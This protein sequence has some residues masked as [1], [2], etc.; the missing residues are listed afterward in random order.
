MTNLNFK[1][2]DKL[3]RNDD[4][5]KI[6]SDT[7]GIRFLKLR[8]MSRKEAMEEFCALHEINLEGIKSKDYFETVFEDRNITDTQISEYINS[9]YQEERAVRA[10]NQEYLVDQLNR[11]QHFDWGGSFGNSLEKNIVNN[12]VKKIQS[13]DKIN[14]EIEGSLLSSMRGYTLNSWYNH[15]TSIIIEDLF[16]DHSSVLPT[17]GLVKKIDFFIND[18][19]F[20]LKVTYFPEQLLADKL[21]DSGYG[22]ELTKLKQA[23]RSLRIFIPDD[24]NPKELK[25]HLLNK[26]REDHRQEAKS[27]VKELG[28]AKKEI[29]EEAERN[30]ADLKKWFYENQGEAR[31]DA[32]NR[33]FLVLTD[34]GDMSASWKLKRNVVFLHEKIHR[35]LDNLALDID[36]LDTEFYWARDQ[37]NYRCKSDILFLKYNGLLQ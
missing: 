2:L 9:R 23:C 19:P 37:R 17:V 21:R 27:F 36:S 1:Q 8:S 20:D 7:R 16:K 24:L 14:V 5:P 11:L 3:F 15:W 28:D 31:F 29:I 10:T 13:F 35:H 34:E 30:P 18:I 32:S 33:F 4:F 6:E 22:N 25:L 26:L 12:Y